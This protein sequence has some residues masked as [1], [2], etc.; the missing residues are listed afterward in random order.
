[1]ETSTRIIDFHLK[2]CIEGQFYKN[3]TSPENTQL[4]FDIIDI[5]S[6]SFVPTDRHESFRKKLSRNPYPKCGLDQK[7]VCE[8]I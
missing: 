8:K 2:G 3:T 1:M 5:F 6:L 7:R 4:L